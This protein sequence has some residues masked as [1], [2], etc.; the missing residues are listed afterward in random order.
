ML[1]VT[2]LIL[3]RDVGSLHVVFL[4]N[5]APAG[6]LTRLFYRSLL[7]TI[8]ACLMVFFNRLEKFRCVILYNFAIDRFV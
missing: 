6:A 3:A 8:L 2:V 1:V 5:L 4:D 7:L